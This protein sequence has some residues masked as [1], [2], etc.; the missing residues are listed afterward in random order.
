MLLANKKTHTIFFSVLQVMR[1]S[2]NFISELKIF[3]FLC[4]NIILQLFQC[5][6]YKIKRFKTELFYSEVSLIWIFFSSGHIFTFSILPWL[7]RLHS[8]Y[9]LYT[10]EL[11]SSQNKRY[12]SLKLH[13]FVILAYSDIF[14]KNMPILWWNINQNL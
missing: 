5:I 10:K 2:F 9:F 4:V 14:D 3:C 13:E 1:K 8:M 11:Y 6:R 12:R 7:K